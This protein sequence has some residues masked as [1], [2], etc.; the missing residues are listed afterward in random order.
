MDTSTWRYGAGNEACPADDPRKRKLGV[1][2]RLVAG[3]VLQLEVTLWSALLWNPRVDVLQV[4]CETSEGGS[5][6]VQL[7]VGSPTAGDVFACVSR[8]ARAPATAAENER[9]MHGFFIG[10]MISPQSTSSLR[11]VMTLLHSSR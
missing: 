8:S 11:L 7:A 4:N 3:R 10:E 9:S 2:E 1:A 6:E 5:A